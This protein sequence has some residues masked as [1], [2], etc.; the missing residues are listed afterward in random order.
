MLPAG[1]E[2]AAWRQASHLVAAPG[3]GG[4][5]GVLAELRG[6]RAPAAGLGSIVRIVRPKAGVTISP[7]ARDRHW[8]GWKAP[9][10]QV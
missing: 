5:T 9:A 6:Y 4:V 10:W 8:P 2:C 1:A 7:R 3:A